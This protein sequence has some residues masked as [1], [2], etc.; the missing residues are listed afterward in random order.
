M[1]LTYCCVIDFKDISIPSFV[2]LVQYST[3]IIHHTW[4]EFDIYSSIL[5]QQYSWY[6]AFTHDSWHSIAIFD[7]R[8]RLSSFYISSQHPTFAGDV[9]HLLSKFTCDIRLSLAT[10][11]STLAIISRHFTF[12]GNFGHSHAA[13]FTRHWSPRRIGVRIGKYLDLT[14]F[15]KTVRD[16]QF[17]LGILINFKSRK[18]F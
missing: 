1:N 7:I 6:L 14:C 8:W 4:N 9:R 16:M 17:Q 12:S 2:K 18:P 15:S 3:S 10:F 13:S 11:V 5:H